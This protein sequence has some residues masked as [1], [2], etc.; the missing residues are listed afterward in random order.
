MGNKEENAWDELFT[1]LHQEIRRMPVLSYCGEGIQNKN[2]FSKPLN[3][4]SIYR[5]VVILEG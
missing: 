4:L 2:K 5:A 3:L 1:E